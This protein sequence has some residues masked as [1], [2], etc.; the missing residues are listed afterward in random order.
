MALV[1]A[2]HPA[3]GAVATMFITKLSADDENLLT[4]KMAVGQKTLAGGPLDQRHLFRLVTVKR[5]HLQ[6][7]LARKPG[8][9]ESINAYAGEVVGLKL[10]E[11]DE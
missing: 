10:M 4:T 1:W 7:P 8:G 2:A 9:V 5:H 11:F 3:T 6:S